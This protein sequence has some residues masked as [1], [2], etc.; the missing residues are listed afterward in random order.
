MNNLTEQEQLTI[1]VNDL[2][3]LDELNDIILVARQRKERIIQ[4]PKIDA[5]SECV[6]IIEKT[7]INNYKMGLIDHNEV[8]IQMFDAIKLA[9]KA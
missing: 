8:L 3:K 6:E 2:K 4:Q 5:A 9:R 7:I 1:R